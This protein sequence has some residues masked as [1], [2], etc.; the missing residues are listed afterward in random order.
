MRLFYGCR[1]VKECEADVT[2]PI[3]AST[4]YL[5]ICVFVFVFV[6]VY[7]HVGEPKPRRHNMSHLWIK[8]VSYP[9]TPPAEVKSTLGRGA[10]NNWWQTQ[11]KQE[12]QVGHVTPNS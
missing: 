3:Y 7:L 8:S 11:E 5:C 10:D 9:V 6:F 1:W 4:V 2:C 12:E